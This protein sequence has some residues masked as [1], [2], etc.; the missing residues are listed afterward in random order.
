LDALCLLPRRIRK[1][2]DET[3]LAAIEDEVDAMLR[4]QLVKSLDRDVST[5][6]AQA[7]IAAAHRI[8]NLIHH[9][10]LLLAARVSA[11]GGTE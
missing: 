8:D 5:S 3:E 2:D 7:L 1:L 9:R 10:R 4:E 11:N 6:E